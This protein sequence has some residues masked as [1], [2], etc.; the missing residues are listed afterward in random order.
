MSSYDDVVLLVIMI[1]II[2]RIIVE[3]SQMLV[4]SLPPTIDVP[5]RPTYPVGAINIVVEW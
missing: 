1:L 5:T 2:I 4:Y 3:S